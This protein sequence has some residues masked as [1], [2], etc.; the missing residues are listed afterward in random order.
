MADVLVVDDDADIRVLLA[1]LL[2]LRGHT[3]RYAVT[4]E[5]AL[6]ELAARRPDVLLLDL[7]LPA[8]DGDDLIELLDRG[9]GRPET[10]YLVS[11]QPHE[12]VRTIAEA[13]GVGYLH[14]PFSPADIDRIV[15][16]AGPA[17][18]AQRPSVRTE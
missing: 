13:H 4:A 7:A 14:K 15:P 8:R 17:H 9:I 18:D 1:T 12:M 11:A 10:V 2:E 16:S 3:V 6:L 5:E